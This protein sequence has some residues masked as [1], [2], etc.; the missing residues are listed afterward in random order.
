MQDSASYQ[1]HISM[2]IFTINCII[3]GG[4][5]MEQLVVS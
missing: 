3:G 5:K 2:D 4:N 1:I